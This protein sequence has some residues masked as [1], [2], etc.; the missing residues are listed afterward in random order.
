M[1]E[2]PGHILK[3]VA[4][5]L[6]EC[7]QVTGIEIKRLKVTYDIKTAGLYG[8]AAYSWMNHIR[9]NPV[10]LV[11]CTDWYISNIVPHEWA[12]LAT[13]R[14]HTPGVRAHGKE[15]KD[16]MVTVGAA[17]LRCYDIPPLPGH[18]KIGPRNRFIIS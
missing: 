3:E 16:M 5:R 10:Y 14:K 12:H 13:F 2:V 1:I 4:A 6:Q 18:V 17:P 7:G 8:D 11:H 15:W 9:F